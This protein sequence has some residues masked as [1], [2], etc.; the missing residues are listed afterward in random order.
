MKKFGSVKIS[1]TCIIINSF[2]ITNDKSLIS[3]IYL[4]QQKKSDM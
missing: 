2:A 3:A 4:D 1:A